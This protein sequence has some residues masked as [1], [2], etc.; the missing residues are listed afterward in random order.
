MKSQIDKVFYSEK[1]KLISHVIN[2]LYL[3]ESKGD[4]VFNINVRR[5]ILV[6]NNDT[7]YFDKRSFFNKNRQSN[8]NNN[9]VRRSFFNEESCFHKCN[10]L[11]K[12]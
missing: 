7:R 1:Y 12:N 9:S 11:T 3:K 5:S 2:F 6:H 4:N 10:R 8:E